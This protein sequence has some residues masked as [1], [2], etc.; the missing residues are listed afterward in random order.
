[1]KK[2]D[3]YNEILTLIKNDKEVSVHTLAQH[4]QVSLA[5]IRRDL[6]YMEDSNML[7]RYHGG[8]KMGSKDFLEPPMDLKANT[9]AS[10]KK[11]VGKYAAKLIKDNQMVYIDAGSATYEMLDHINS[12]NITV[13]T[14]GLP[15][16]TK[17]VEK[18][19]NTLMLGGTVRPSTMAI[20][21]NKPVNQLDEYYFDVAFLGT[22]AIHPHGGL[23]TTN[24]TEALVKHKVISRSNKTYA[25]ADHSKFNMIYPCIFANVDEITII[26]DDIGNYP[27]EKPNN[28][29]ELAPKAKKTDES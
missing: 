12:K 10:A 1:M 20:T 26:T 19:I 7:Q 14:I 2:R 28:V 18:G 6:Q 21:G 22:N 17:L 11:L 24:D 25:L 3:R 16:V 23:S 4:F 27:K 29:I 13:V 15:H 9:N 8:A 5:T